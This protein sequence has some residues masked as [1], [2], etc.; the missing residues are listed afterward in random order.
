MMKPE[1]RVDATEPNMR[2]QNQTTLME[3][4]SLSF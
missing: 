1:A 2:L 3:L 4:I